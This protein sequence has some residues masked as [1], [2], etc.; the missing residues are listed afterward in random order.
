MHCNIQSQF[1]AVVGRLSAGMPASRYPP[2]VALY[3]GLLILTHVPCTL[4]SLKL[5][6][7]GAPEG[8]GRLHGKQIP[9]I[10]NGHGTA[11]QGHK[12]SRHE[13]ASRQKSLVHDGCQAR[14]NDQGHKGC[15]L[16]QF[17]LHA[18][19]H[20]LCRDLYRARLASGRGQ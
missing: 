14:S 17:A 16:A 4:A 3:I 9:H 13:L 1:K 2:Y 20:A 18:I 6:A 15:R 10:E 12:P 5:L 19:R 7:S 8:G 11:E